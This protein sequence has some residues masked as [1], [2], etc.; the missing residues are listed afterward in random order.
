MEKY[1]IYYEAFDWAYKHLTDDAIRLRFLR[2][3]IDYGLYGIEPESPV[4]ALAF[5]LI[6]Q[7][8]DAQKIRSNQAKQNGAKGGR[9]KKEQT[10]GVVRNENTQTQPFTIVNTDPKGDFLKSLEQ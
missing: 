8:M 2:E 7:K 4:D 9:P 3:V 6:K 5:V 10:N 1:F